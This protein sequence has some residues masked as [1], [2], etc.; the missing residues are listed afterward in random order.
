MNF[1]DCINVSKKIN[2]SI[3]RSI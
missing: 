1:Q 2:T 3:V